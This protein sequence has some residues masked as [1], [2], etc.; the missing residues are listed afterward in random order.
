MNDL[1]RNTF[2]LFD[3][4]LTPAQEA[5]FERYENELLSWNNRFNLTAIQEP[6]QVQTKHFLDSLSCLSIMRESPVEK[7]IDVGSGAGFPGIPLKIVL[8]HIHLTL[9]ES[10]G[11]KVSFLNHL[12]EV[13]GLQNIN[14]VNERVEV[15]GQQSQHR[16]K[17]DW[18]IARAVAVMPVLAEYLLPLVRMGGKMLAMKGQNAPAETQTADRAFRIL[19]G[20]LRRL[21]PVT[22][23]GV[24]D[25]RYL[26]VIDKVAATPESYPRRVGIPAKKPL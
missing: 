11:K 17:Y 16:Q 23:P 2:Q 21:V 20:H 8:P 15:L 24:T 18:A 13:L 7:I 1:S 9:V 4:R 25:E 19:G 22:L 5:A 6:S 26:V 14:V 10:V 3:L 12:I